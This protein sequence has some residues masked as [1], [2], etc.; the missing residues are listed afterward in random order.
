M[1]GNANWYGGIE[2]CDSGP[3]RLSSLSQAT[4]VPPEQ[5]AEMVLRVATRGYVLSR[6]RVVATDDAASLRTSSIVRNL[7]FS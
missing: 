6:W 2:D 3:G 1:V 7:Y 4:I 5:S